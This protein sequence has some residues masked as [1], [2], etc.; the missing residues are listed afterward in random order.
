MKKFEVR[1]APANWE[2][3]INESGRYVPLRDGLSYNGLLNLWN[4]GAVDWNPANPFYEE[5][6]S[7]EE[8]AGTCPTPGQHMPNWPEAERKNLMMYDVSANAGVPVSPSFETA[9]GLCRWL[10]EHQISLGGVWTG[11]HKPSVPRASL[12]LS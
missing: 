7:Y 5:G 11:G 10:V 2:H 4:T 8:W 6:V 9:E 1:R 3:P 12:Q